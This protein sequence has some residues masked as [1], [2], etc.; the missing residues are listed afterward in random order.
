MTFKL[1]QKWT[2][3]KGSIPIPVGAHAAVNLVNR[4]LVYRV[5]NKVSSYS[6]HSVGL[7]E[8]IQDI[9]ES[10]CVFFRDGELS[11]TANGYILDIHNPSVSSIKSQDSQSDAIPLEPIE[12]DQLGPGAYSSQHVSPDFSIFLSNV[13]QLTNKLQELW[14]HVYQKDYDLV[15]LTEVCPKNSRAR[16]EDSHI[17]MLRYRVVY[18]LFFT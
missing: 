7:S 6:E 15:L 12:E 4:G 14:S 17:N 16:L 3:P 9:R 18:S 10:S 1:Y 11:P 13:D 5:V 2:K 8:S